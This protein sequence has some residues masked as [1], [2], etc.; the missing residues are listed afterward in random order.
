MSDATLK[1]ELLVREFFTIPARK[2]ETEEQ[3]H[4][5][6]TYFVHDDRIVAVA[7]TEPEEPSR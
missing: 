3:P 2:I 7:K 1:M 5:G 6:R 4:T